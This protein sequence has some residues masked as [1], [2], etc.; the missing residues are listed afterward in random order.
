MYSLFYLVDPRLTTVNVSLITSGAILLVVA[1][2]ADA[3]FLVL[4]VQ[5]LKPEGKLCYTMYNGQ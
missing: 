2:V 1:L 5:R 4:V 3:I